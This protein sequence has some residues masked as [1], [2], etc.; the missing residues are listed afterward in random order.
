[1][2]TKKYIYRV[3]EFAAKV[4]MSP[5][6]IRRMDNDGRFPARRSTTGQRYYDDA[7]VRRFLNLPIANHAATVVYCRVSSSSQRRDLQ[8][9]ILCMENFCS[10]SGIV[11]DE[12]ISE[13]GG[14]M[15]MKRPKF[16]D[17]VF[18]ISQGQ[19]CHLL[20]S[21]KDR[22]SRFGFDLIEGLA[23]RMG[24]KIT[25]VNQ[26]SSSPDSEL[27][28]DLL[29]VV[30]TFSCRLYGLRKYKTILRNESLTSDAD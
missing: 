9:Q 22:L 28:E 2:S 29:A 13:V 10:S 24:C 5:E 7:D 30:H 23:E 3:A 11:V 19:V 15:N 4:G 1:M 17:L 27:V 21:H 8:S 12:W 16:L 6:T 20:V 26:P 25:V 14:G 18:R